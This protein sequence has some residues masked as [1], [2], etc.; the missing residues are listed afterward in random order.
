MIALA[1]FGCSDPTQPAPLP[2]STPNDRYVLTGVVAESGTRA[3]LPNARV[4]VYDATID[5]PYKANCQLTGPDGSYRI[6]AGRG[7]PARPGGTWNPCPTASAADF[8][9]RQDC[10]SLTSPETTWSPTLQ[11]II[12][13]EAGQTVAATIVADDISGLF[14][15]RC[16][17]CKRV[18]MVAIR[19]GRVAVRLL[20]ENAGLRLAF[21][22]LDR[23]ADVPFPVHA[24][25]ES[26]IT[27]ASENPGASQSFELST[28]YLPN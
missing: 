2:T 19:D 23:S 11:R 28:A 7:E 14:D 5:D 16:V 1:G 25:E 6:V 21:D 27:I 3:P 8:E 17:R 26:S 18:R 24:G 10:I 22:H 12:R 4:C 20:P 9:H 13:M 15:D